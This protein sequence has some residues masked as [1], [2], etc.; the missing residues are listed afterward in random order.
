[1]VEICQKCNEIITE[2]EQVGGIKIG[3]ID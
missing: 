2:I 1:M 3:G